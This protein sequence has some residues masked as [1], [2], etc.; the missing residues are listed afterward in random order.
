MD[1]CRV[2]M[3]T[4]VETGGTA[5]E[6]RMTRITRIARMTRITRITRKTRIAGSQE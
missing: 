2:C 4:P 1:A 3:E 6:T 5:L